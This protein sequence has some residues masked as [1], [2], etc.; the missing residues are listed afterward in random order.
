MPDE[1]E[2]DYTAVLLALTKVAVAV[3]LPEDERPER[4]WQQ[5]A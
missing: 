1:Q 5:A 2:D 3:S 4:C